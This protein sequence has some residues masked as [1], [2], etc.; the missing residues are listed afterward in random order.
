[1]P[2]LPDVVIYIERLIPLVLS[3]RLEGLRV[4]SPFLVRSFDPPLDSAQGKEVLGLRRLGKRIVF[5]LED[6]LHLVLPLMVAGRLQWR[7][8]SA[9]IPRKIGL[10]AMD[11][12]N[13]ALIITEAG[14]RKR[15]SL[16]LVRGEESLL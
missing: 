4:A 5:S 16:Y 3:R 10:A 9:G 6:E 12:T 8:A 14:T 15:A 2:E 13:G 11:F 1:M 7:P